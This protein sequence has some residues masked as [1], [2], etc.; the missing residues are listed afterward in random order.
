MTTS[1]N[2]PS[3]PSH[4]ACNEC[5]RG[6]QFTRDPNYTCGQR[7]AESMAR[8]TAPPPRTNIDGGDPRDRARLADI[9][10]A[11]AQQSAARQARDATILLTC[12][13]CLTATLHIPASSTPERTQEI[14]R[15]QGWTRAGYCGPRCEGSAP[16][17]AGGPIPNAG[18]PIA[19]RSYQTAWAQSRR[20]QGLPTLEMHRQYVEPEPAPAPSAPPAPAPTS[21]AKP[22]PRPRQ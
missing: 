4:L 2:Y 9:E 11:Q 17:P 8:T 6:R 5:R 15:V 19:D 14:L 12:K 7:H 18:A 1:T 13:G 10:R 20:R 21:A 3:T 16:K 22:S